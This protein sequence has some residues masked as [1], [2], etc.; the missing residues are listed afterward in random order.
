MIALDSA[1]LARVG[2]YDESFIVCHAAAACLM[3][4]YALMHAGRR[5][6][7]FNAGRCYII[8]H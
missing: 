5:S 6:S 2:S 4:P 7:A 1:A 3:L 8:G